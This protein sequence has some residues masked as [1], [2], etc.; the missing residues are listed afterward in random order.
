MRPS[1]QR[2]DADQF[3]L[4]IRARYR[5]CVH[6]LTRLPSR[7]PS[8]WSRN[9]PGQLVGDPAHGRSKR[10]IDFDTSTSRQ[11][12]EWDSS[13]IVCRR[14]RVEHCLTIAPSAS[15]RPHLKTGIQPRF[16][17]SFLKEPE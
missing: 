8:R 10:L 15:S 9:D 16:Q 17:D 4:V 3:D 1:Q 5:T 11:N 6:D 7:P 12:G 13:A 2:I 14:I